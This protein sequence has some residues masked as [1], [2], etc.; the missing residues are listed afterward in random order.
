MI[1]LRSWLMLLVCS[2]SIKSSIGEQA[3]ASNAVAGDEVELE[4]QVPGA[5]NPSYDYDWEEMQRLYPGIQRDVLNECT[6]PGQEGCLAA[7]DFNYQPT[8]F[9]MDDANLHPA[10]GEGAGGPV[11]GDSGGGDE[12]G[13][14]AAARRRRQPTGDEQYAAAVR[15]AEEGALAE[16]LDHFVSG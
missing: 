12:D 9:G 8:L 5:A 6:E 2:L 11:P 1:L 14:G 7:G 3:A 10:A 16:P 4:A 15:E 13:G